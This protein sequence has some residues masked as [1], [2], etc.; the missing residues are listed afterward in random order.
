MQCLKCCNLTKNQVIKKYSIEEYKTMTLDFISKNQKSLDWDRISAFSE[1]S[2]E[3][4]FRFRY[5]LNKDLISKY[6][7]LSN[8]FLINHP[9]LLNWKIV[10]FYQKEINYENIWRYF[11]YLN[12][13]GFLHKKEIN[14][15]DFFL[16][17]VKFPAYFLHN[18][19]QTFK[20]YLNYNFKPLFKNL[21]KYQT[22]TEKIIINNKNILNWY[23]IT[24]YQNISFDFLNIVYIYIDWKVYTLKYFCSHKYYTYLPDDI[25]YLSITNYMNYIQWKE[26][27]KYV[28]FLPENY[29]IG[30]SQEMKHFKQTQP[31]YYSIYLYRYKLLLKLQKHIIHY[32]YKPD[33]GP[34]FLKIKQK[35]NF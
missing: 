29:I 19:I 33:N 7:P 1:L 18:F 30:H 27:I 22:L 13:K 31:Y 14:I 24:K 32:L 5:K 4:I 34:M 16:L 17:N 9:Y 12:L 2:S 8:E 21:Y 28:S 11:M 6:Q 35:Y 23:Y 25:F 15:I 3:F 26:V 10:L 20:L